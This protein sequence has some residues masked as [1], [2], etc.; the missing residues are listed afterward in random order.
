M[1]TLFYTVNGKIEE[2][3]PV[4][5]YNI[6]RQEAVNAFDALGGLDFD[7]TSASE[8]MDSDWRPNLTGDNLDT[9][10]RSQLIQVTDEQWNDYKNALLNEVEKLVET[11]R[12]NISYA[13]AALGRLGGSVKSERKAAASRENG[14]L[15]GRPRKEKK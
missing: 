4:E 7:R 1:I 12:E 11:A 9:G 13:A 10:E 14:K 15:G 5:Y 6:V 8:F 2:Q 3:E